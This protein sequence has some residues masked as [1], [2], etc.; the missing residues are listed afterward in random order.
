MTLA[1]L[2]DA[3][4]EA[5]AA[6]L[7]VADPTAA[8]ELAHLLASTQGAAF[9]PGRVPATSPAL[10]QYLPG[11]LAEPFAAPLGPVAPALAAVWEQL[12]WVYHYAEREDAPGLG[13]RVAFAELVGPRG[14][15]GGPDIKMGFTFLAPDVLYPAHAHPAAELYVV[16]SGRALWTQSGRAAWRDPGAVIVHASEEPHAMQTAG[17]PLLALYGWRGALDEPSRYV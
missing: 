7:A 13:S 6:L 17:E 10:R 8:V 15:L 11:V 1:R 12:Q 16:L 5:A 9:L 14:P 2:N 4:R 3:I